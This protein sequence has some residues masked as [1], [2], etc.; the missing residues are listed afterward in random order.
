M[1]QETKSEKKSRTASNL[2]PHMHKVA[3]VQEKLPK[4]SDELNSVVKQLNTASITD[5]NA[6]ISHLKVRAHELGVLAAAANAGNIDTGDEVVVVSGDPKFVGLTGR[7]VEKRRIRC[8]V[9]VP[10]MQTKLYLFTSDV[11]RVAKEEDE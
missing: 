6:V 8:F 9:E 11:Q 2:I 5:L 3:K 10:G 1:S 7:V 4:L